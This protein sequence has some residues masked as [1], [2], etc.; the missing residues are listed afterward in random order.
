M[1]HVEVK[2]NQMLFNLRNWPFNINSVCA[3]YRKNCFDEDSLMY[4]I[5]PANWHTAVEI[6]L[7]QNERPSWIVTRVSSRRRESIAPEGK[8]WG[9]F[10]THCTRRI[11]ISYRR[12]VPNSLGGPAVPRDDSSLIFPRRRD[13]TIGYAIGAIVPRIRTFLPT[14]IYFSCHRRRTCLHT[15]NASSLLLLSGRPTNSE[16]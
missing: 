12:L 16:S 7:C 6:S 8:R 5:N 14:S 1:T 15:L 3:E 13:T 10:P 9:T 11:P 4:T 2:N